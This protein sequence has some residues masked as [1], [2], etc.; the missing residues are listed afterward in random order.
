MQ[1]LLP[2][3]FSFSPLSGSSFFSSA[4][5]NLHPLKDRGPDDDHSVGGDQRDH[6]VHGEH[7]RRVRVQPGSWPGPHPGLHRP[8]GPCNVLHRG[9]Q[10]AVL[11]KL[12]SDM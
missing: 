11:T 4:C 9:P 3:G 8:T 1:G 10:V 5:T 7:L 12:L 2:A 6:V